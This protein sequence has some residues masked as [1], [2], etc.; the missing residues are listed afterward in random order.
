VNGSPVFWSTF[1]VG[2]A[3]RIAGSSPSNS[4]STT[5]PMTWAILPVATAPTGAAAT[6]AVFGAAGLRAG[7]LLGAAG[8]GMLS[9]RAEALDGFGTAQTV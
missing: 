4:T 2:R 5:A 3:L 6:L 9:R 7:G 1:W 8:S